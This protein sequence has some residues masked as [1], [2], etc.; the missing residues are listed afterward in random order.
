MHKALNLFYSFKNDGVKTHFPI[1]YLAF[2][3]KIINFS[4]AYYMDI[5]HN[6][7]ENLSN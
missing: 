5:S 6:Q 4:N 7:F 3:F 1:I 2:E